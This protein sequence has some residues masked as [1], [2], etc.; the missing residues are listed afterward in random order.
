[1][2]FTRELIIYSVVVL[3]IFYLLF[4]Y[5]FIKLKGKLIAKLKRFF[6]KMYRFIFRYKF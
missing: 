3:V 1:M 5:N 4:K 2:N 6:I